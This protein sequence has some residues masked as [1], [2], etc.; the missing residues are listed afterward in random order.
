MT[1]DGRAGRTHDRR[2]S[3]LVLLATQIIRVWIVTAA[4][5]PVC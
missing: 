5:V 1:S 4:H 2:L 3:A